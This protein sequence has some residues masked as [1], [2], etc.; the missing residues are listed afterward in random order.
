MNDL[1]QRLDEATR[2]IW[3]ITG[4]A[5]LTALSLR[6]G[7]REARRRAAHTARLEAAALTCAACQPTGGGGGL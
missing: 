4:L 7:G 1:E 5:L 6:T 3:V 2:T